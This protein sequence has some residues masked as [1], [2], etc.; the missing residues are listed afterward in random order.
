[1]EIINWQSKQQH[2]VLHYTTVH[3]SAISETFFFCYWVS[4]DLDSELGERD[5]QSAEANDTAIDCVTIYF[6][7]L[8]IWLHVWWWL[9]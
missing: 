7:K 3:K 1:M 9:W 6:F 4:F 8:N 2:L 5:D